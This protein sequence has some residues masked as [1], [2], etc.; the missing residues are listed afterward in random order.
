MLELS[1][2]GYY[3]PILHLGYFALET[4]FGMKLKATSNARLNPSGRIMTNMLGNYDL[5]H[6]GTEDE[7]KATVT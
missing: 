4:I 1:T 6:A 5:L 3:H 2:D 7:E